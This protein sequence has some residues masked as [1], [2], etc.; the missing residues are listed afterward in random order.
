MD[1]NYFGIPNPDPHHSE[2]PAVM[3]LK[4]EPLRAVDA[5]N[6]GV[7]GLYTRGRRFASL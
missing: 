2:K 1:P 3:R 4:M 6:R 7:E 5:K